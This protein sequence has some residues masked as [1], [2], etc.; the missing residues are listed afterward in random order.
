MLEIL[1]RLLGITD[2]SQ[3]ALLS[4]LL[5]EAQSYVEDYLQR[6]LSLDTYQDVIEPN[7]STSIWLRNYP[8]QSVDSIES[9]DGHRVVDFKIIKHTGMV[10][11]NKN[12]IG[13]FIVEYQGGYE[14]LPA[15]ATKAIV[16]SAAYLYGQEG[17]GGS[18]ASGAIKQEEIYGVAKIVYDTQVSGASGDI[19]GV[20]PFSVVETLE[21]H[22]NRYA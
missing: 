10:R 8:V 5:G 18:G 2:D 22:K 20:L 9:L 4:Q 16:D 13:D 3:D 12:L 11:T 7:G 1:K 21:R 17:S 15:W 19:G 6:E 14:T